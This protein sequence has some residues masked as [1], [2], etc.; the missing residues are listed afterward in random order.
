[1]DEG[2]SPFPAFLRKQ[3]PKRANRLL[4][5]MDSCFRRGAELTLRHACAGR[6]PGL[7]AHKAPPLDPRLRGDDDVP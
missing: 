5:A 3:E 2:Q 4:S 1:M 6:H 7:L